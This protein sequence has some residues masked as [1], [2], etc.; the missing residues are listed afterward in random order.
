MA[1]DDTHVTLTQEELDALIEKECQTRL[2]ISRETFI[3]RYNDGTF[4]REGNGCL[5]CAHDGKVRSISMWFDISAKKVL[6]E[7]EED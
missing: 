5:C 6:K 7:P 3:Q 2:G 1:D 4:R